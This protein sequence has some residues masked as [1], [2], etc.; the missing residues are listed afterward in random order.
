M[1]NEADIDT[2][3]QKVVESTVSGLK[4]LI[5]AEI[6]A[7]RENE[8]EQKIRRL[9]PALHPDKVTSTTLE[10]VFTRVTQMLNAERDILRGRS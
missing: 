7:V 1:A 8:R 9:L 6:Q 4:I 2:P 5:R 3:M 10:P